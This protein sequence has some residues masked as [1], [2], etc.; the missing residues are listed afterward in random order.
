MANNSLWGAHL[1]MPGNKAG[2]LCK[3]PI[4]NVRNIIIDLEFATKMPFK[5]DGRYLTR[6][7]ISYIR[8]V[9]PDINICV[10]VNLSCARKLQDDDIK[11]ISQSRPNSIRIPSVNDKYEIEHVDGLLT[12]IEK[13]NG[14]DTGCIKLHPMIETPTGLRNAAEIIKASARVEAIALGGEDW[15]FNCGLHRT[16]EGHEL[17]HVK[18]EMI[19]IA[20]ENKIIAIDTVFSYLEDRDGLIEDCK[21]SRMLGFRARSTI[22]PRQLQIINCAYLPTKD[23][24]EWASALLNDLKEVRIGESLNYVSQG[25]IID[26]LAIFQA[27]SILKGVKINEYD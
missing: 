15:A 25:I 19:T 16:R 14:W 8:S 26:P 6:N 24:L 11:I 1:F 12:K 23:E 17:E 21:C 20:A 7:A 27:K 4:L 10:R 18:V 22:N 3:L 5:V 2:F 9:R 13:E